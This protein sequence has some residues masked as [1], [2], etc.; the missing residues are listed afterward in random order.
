MDDAHVGPQRVITIARGSE[1]TRQGQQLL[2]TAYERMLPIHRC[3][4]ATEQA[5]RDVCPHHAPE[6]CAPQL[7]MAGV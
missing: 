3:P 2:A 6:S 5:P 1:Y 4:L 7:E